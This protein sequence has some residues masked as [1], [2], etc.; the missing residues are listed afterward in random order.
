MK[1]TYAILAALLLLALPSR[2]DSLYE[3]TGTATMTGNNVCGGP[4]V[5]AVNFTFDLD[6]SFDP[7]NNWYFLT[8]DAASYSA[9]GPLTGPALGTTFRQDMGYYLPIAFTG[10]GNSEFDLYFTGDNEPQPF[11]PG[12]FDEDIYSCGDQTCLDDFCPPADA[13]CQEAP[14]V[15]GLFI[16]RSSIEET[17]TPLQV[18]TPEP[19]E[20]G[21][22]ALGIA[23]LALSALCGWFLRRRVNTREICGA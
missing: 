20:S 15:Y 2:A 16:D 12:V 22:L 14:P 10:N 13:Q 19:S 6:E 1:L 3:V 7:V 9:S 8:V 17:V 11:V 23:L 21:L 18:V 5:E 4:C